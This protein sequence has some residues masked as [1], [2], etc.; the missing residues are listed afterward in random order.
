[1]Y[2]AGMRGFRWGYWAYPKGPWAYPPPVVDLYSFPFDSYPQGTC[3]NFSILDLR[4]LDDEEL[5]QNVAVT[6][7]DDPRIPRRDKEKIQV[8]V[9]ERVATLTGEVHFKGSKVQA[10]LDALDTPGIA[11]VRNN[12]KIV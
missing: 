8:E 6:I 11:D 12:I 7:Y 5:R 10:Y 4:L 2:F 3:A 1:M 9:K